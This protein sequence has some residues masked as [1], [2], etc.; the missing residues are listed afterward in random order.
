VGP[1]TV[2]GALIVR[3]VRSIRAGN[4]HRWVLAV[5]ACYSLTGNASFA[6]T[7]APPETAVV[8][9]VVVDQATEALL[10]TVEQQISSEHI[11]S[12]PNDNALE[13]WR[14][15]L[16]RNLTTHGSPGVLR[17]LADFETRA[18]NLAA[19]DKAAGNSVAAAT[20]TVFAD[21]AT[22]LAGNL[23]QS[24]SPGAPDPDVVTRAAPSESAA[25]AAPPPDIARPDRSVAPDRTVASAPAAAPPA[26]PTDQAASE[27][28]PADQHSREADV[29]PAQINPTQPGPPS[30]A[31]SAATAAPPPAAPGP[32]APPVAHA[33]T[34]RESAM[35]DFYAR[36]GDETLALKDISAARKFYEYAA[37]A[38]SARAATALAR[39]FD[40][41]FIAQL[42]VVGLKPDAE[43]AATWYR[44]AGALG[45][46][47]SEAQFLTQRAATA[48]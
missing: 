34:E 35:A 20:L 40:A 9:S 38:G 12:P 17:A 47:H 27:P 7:E 18:R 11:V 10:H 48:K 3:A 23:P 1:P 28:P 19:S 16:Q 42:G 8:P 31:G 25:A 32:P 39:T 45:D 4:L 36:R 24:D 5:C 26:S 14:Q 15:V 44:K 46:S 21:E 2:S 29:T 43:L 13:T 37:N 41:A 6:D 22:R 30:V 33:R